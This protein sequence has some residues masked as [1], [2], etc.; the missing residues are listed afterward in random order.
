MRTILLAGEGVSNWLALVSHMN[1]R[2]EEG[3]F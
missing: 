2:E 1:K 3:Y